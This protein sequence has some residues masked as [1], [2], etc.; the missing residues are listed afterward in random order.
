MN[1]GDLIKLHPPST[2]AEVQTEEVKTPAGEF[3]ASK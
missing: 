3:R 2:V 1:S